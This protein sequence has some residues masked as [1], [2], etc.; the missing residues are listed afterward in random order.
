MLW[1]K[2]KLAAAIVC[3]AAAVGGGAGA[4][5]AASGG[6][7][8]DQPAPPATARPEDKSAF[9]RAS[10]HAQAVEES[11]RPIRPGVPGKAPFWNGKAIQFIYAPAFDFKPVKGAAVY[12][13][14]ATVGGKD[15]NFEAAEP[16]APLTPIW[17]DLPVGNATLKV[18][19]LA[20]PGGAVLGP[21]GSRGFYRA[22]VFNGPYNDPPVLDYAASGQLICKGLIGAQWWVQWRDEKKDPKEYGGMVY[23]SKFAGAVVSGMAAYAGISPPP[24]DRDQAL[25][26]ARNA[27]RC[28]IRMSEPAGKPF[29][30]FPPTYH[31]KSSGSIGKPSWIMLNYP[32]EVANAYLDL[33]AV[34]KEAEFLEAARRIADTFKKTQGSN[35]SW[36][37]LV[38]KETGKQ[39]G[40]NTLTPIAT[41]VLFD[42][43]CSEHGLKDYEAALKATLGYVK[44]HAA[45]MALT[46]QFEDI[47]ID[48]TGNLSPNPA[49]ET[50]EYLLRH[51]KDA[52][53]NVPLAEDLLHLAED[54]FVVWEPQG[55]RGFYTPAALEQ[56]AYF[57]PV[58]YSAV[59]YTRACVTAYEVT[60][61]KLYLAKAVSMAN[62]MTVIQD[63]TGKPCNLKLVPT[64]WKPEEWPRGDWPNCLIAPGETLVRLGDKL[65]RFR[66]EALGA[67]R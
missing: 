46:G 64:L 6:Q 25:K 10:L 15:F 39:V 55:D 5:L 16:W 29:E 23:P 51:A 42:R 2:V 38:D 34:T 27:A 3:G 35:G 36:P 18:E 19:G 30:H 63:K 12:R 48:A 60:G 54:Q 58:N 24:A 65:S 61:R 62:T 14:T 37:M 11:L 56:Y 33:Y 8:A 67:S 17:K 50:A 21:A 31:P 59:L 22:A 52:P 4:V 66:A 41:L 1:V 45:V 26:M 44:G 7:A 40:P 32:G 13:F 20:A 57:T 28:L 47:R 53:E 49:C 43:L 9:D